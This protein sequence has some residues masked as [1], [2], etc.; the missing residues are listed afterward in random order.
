MGYTLKKKFTCPSLLTSK[1]DPSLFVYSHANN[2]IY[3]LVYVD[4]IIITGNNTAFLRNIVSQLNSA[5]SLKDL[6]QLDYFLGIE[7]KSN[8]DGSLTLTQSK[9]VRDLLSR[10]DMENSKPIASPM[11]SGCKLS[12]SG[13]DK[14]LNVSLY[15]F[16]VG[17]L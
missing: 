6:G 1:C 7:V 12:K 17:A 8:S 10:T 9:Y 2:I 13:S 16:V 15:R 5:F 14:F 3:I 11:V 4:D